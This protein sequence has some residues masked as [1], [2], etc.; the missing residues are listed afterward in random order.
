MIANEIQKKK[1]F[2]TFEFT[3]GLRS[4]HETSLGHF[5]GICDVLCHCFSG[6]AA[7]QHHRERFTIQQGLGLLS[8][9]LNPSPWSCNL[10]LEHF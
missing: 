4:V 7:H 10:A 5:L 8:D 9:P 3:S 6:S 2:T 1:T